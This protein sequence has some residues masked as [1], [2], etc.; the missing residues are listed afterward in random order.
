MAKRTFDILAAST[1]L[2][3][4]W[5][6][7]LMVA[8]LVKLDSPGPII[9]S[10]RRLGRYGVPFTQ[11]KFR[12]MRVASTT[13]DCSVGKYDERITKVGVVIRQL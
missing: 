9:F 4:L 10:G 13:T 2:L 1:A 5:P 6:L 7:M 3:L 8:I 12:S 11:Y